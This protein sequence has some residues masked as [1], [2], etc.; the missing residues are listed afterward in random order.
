MIQICL[1]D[2]D[3]RRI[4]SLAAKQG[5]TLQDAVVEAFDAWA[6]KLRSGG[7]SQTTGPEAFP[8]AGR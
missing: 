6:E 3:R 7:P 8:N 2:S 1:T 5:L 4:K